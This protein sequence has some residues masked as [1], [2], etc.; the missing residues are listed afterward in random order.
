MIAVNLNAMRLILCTLFGS[1]ASGSGAL[2]MRIVHSFFFLSDERLNW[3]EEE[4][5]DL[6]LILKMMFIPIE[7]TT[8]SCWM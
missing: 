5:N 8:K 6:D 7:S 2:A 3:I 4:K 1:V